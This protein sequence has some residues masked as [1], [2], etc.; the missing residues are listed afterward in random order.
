MS[1]QEVLNHYNRMVEIYP[2][3][4][5]PDHEPKQFQ[6]FVKLY[7]RFHASASGAS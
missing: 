2:N 1:D 4:P 7:L 6:Y 3:L 5:D